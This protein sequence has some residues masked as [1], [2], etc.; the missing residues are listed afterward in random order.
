MRS[1]IVIRAGRLKRPA[2]AESA[3]I[4][5]TRYNVS[6]GKSWL[7]EIIRIY[8]PV[9]IPFGR[10]TGCRLDEPRLDLPVELHHPP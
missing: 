10:G 2:D 3:T 4:K 1:F 6:H 9:N 7:Q 8:V 5:R